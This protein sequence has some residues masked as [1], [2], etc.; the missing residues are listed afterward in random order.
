MNATALRPVFVRAGLVVLAL[1][2]AFGLRTVPAEADG[3]VSVTI[4]DVDD[5]AFPDVRVVASIEENGRPAPALTAGQ[6]EATEG[7][8]PARV[9]AIAETVDTTIPLAMVLALDTSA[10]M[11]DGEALERAQESAQV[12]IANMAANDQVAVVSFA[13]AAETRVPL[14]GDRAAASAAV[15][16]L[17]AKGDTAL[18]D[19]VALSAELTKEAATTRRAVILLSDGEDY[20]Q[21]SKATRDSSLASAVASGTIFYTVGIGPTVDQAYLQE[22]ASRT[23]GRFYLAPAASDVPEIFDSLEQALRGQYIITLRSAG[24]PAAQERQLE[25]TV[26]LSSAA[27][28]TATYQSRREPAAPEPITE[29]P[30]PE[31]ATPAAA[32]APEPAR[33]NDGSSFVPLLAGGAALVV[34][35]A[36]AL[37]V[38]ARRR[39]G[40]GDEEEVTPPKAAEP[41]QVRRRRVGP[42]VEPP[43]VLLVDDL[44]NR[45]PV[46]SE[47]LTLGSDPSCSIRLPEEPG[48]APFHARIWGADGRAMLHHLAAGFTTLVNLAPV[49]WV[50]LSPGDQVSIGHHTLRCIAGDDAR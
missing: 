33:D 10:S 23:G 16:A 6:L 25:L 24:D 44:G 34:L 8:A 43:A 18:F 19:A 31:V 46:G 32:A 27:S 29:T 3:P 48:L 4:V 26:H 22:L 15:R 17:T 9:E 47:P 50:S 1:V 42:E 21:L 38:V 39:A 2:A 5:S 13:N 45:F 28:A 20:G 36:V 37:L 7:G 49:D 11:N 30:V 41:V 40:T 35:A 12:L 14:S